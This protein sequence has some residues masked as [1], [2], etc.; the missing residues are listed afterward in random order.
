[1]VVLR[2]SLWV[3]LLLLYFNFNAKAQQDAQFNLGFLNRVF[4][5]SGETGNTTENLFRAAM[6]N[7]LEL[8]NF[9]GA[10]VTNV[11]NF[12]GPVTLFGISSGVGVT[13]YNDRIGSLRSPG[14]NF[15]Y[16]YR[17]PVFEGTIGMGLEMGMLSSWYVGDGWHLPGGDTDPVIPEQE[18]SKLN[19]DMGLGVAYNSNTWLGG[20]AVK[21]LTAP[22]IGIERIA[23]FRQTLY[24]HAG[25]KYVFADSEWMIMPMA[26]VITDFTQHSWQFHA[27]ARY[28]EK[29][30]I[31]V[32]YRWGQAL[33]GMLGADLFKGVEVAYAYEFLTSA[34]NRFSGGCHELTVS[35]SFSLIVPRGIQR[36]KSIRYL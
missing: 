26:N 2:K 18:G 9:E 25:Y 7:R 22:R 24:V 12:H 27:V 15:M 30:W 16:A 5:N 19:F 34:L 10:P 11:I 23:Q 31:G 13:V 6:A 32:G 35:Y 17:R 21:H 8:V 20:V 14:F 29:Y 33:S 3:S 1:M 28:S 4:S 36:Y